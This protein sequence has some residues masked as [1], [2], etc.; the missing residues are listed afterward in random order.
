MMVQGV[1]IQMC[2]HQH[3]VDRDLQSHHEVE[4]C[5][6]KSLSVTAGKRVMFFL[7]HG[8]LKKTN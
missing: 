4:E 2:S 8:I 6:M 7:E 1:A 5:D 3:K